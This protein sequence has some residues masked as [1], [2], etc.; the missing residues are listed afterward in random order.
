[1]SWGFVNFALRTRRAGGFAARVTVFFLVALRVPPAA[2]AVFLVVVFF[3]VVGFLVAF[4]VAFLRVAFFRAE[5]APD[6]CVRVRD[7]PPEPAVF[8]RAVERDDEAR[9]VD[10]P[11]FLGLG[12]LDVDLREVVF[13]ARLM[14]AGR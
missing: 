3:L 13:F 14:G 9:E 11:A 8:L 7:E 1:L 12:F 6:F 4:F 2:A 10:V 5:V